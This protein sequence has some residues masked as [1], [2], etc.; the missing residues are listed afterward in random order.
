MIAR[1]QA[2]RTVSQ[3]GEMELVSSRGPHVAGE[4]YTATQAAEQLQCSY[5][6][7]K[8]LAETG[9]FPGAVKVGR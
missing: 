3:L 9:R 4:P 5:R 8:R 1:R 2:S 6:W 7:V